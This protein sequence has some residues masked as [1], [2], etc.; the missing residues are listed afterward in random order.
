MFNAHP[1][2]K[3]TQIPVSSEEDILNLYDK[4]SNNKKLLLKLATDY[5]INEILAWIVTPET[6]ND[7]ART[8]YLVE[9]NLLDRPTPI[10]LETNPISTAQ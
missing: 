2:D 4:I 5:W 7:V 1:I 9:N 3:N 10:Y 8:H 6:I